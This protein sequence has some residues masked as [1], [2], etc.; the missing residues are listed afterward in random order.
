M[1]TYPPKPSRQAGCGRPSL[2]RG[3]P[4]FAVSIPRSSDRRAAAFT[5]LAVSF[6]VA[7][8]GSRDDGGAPPAFPDGVYRQTITRQDIVGAF[9]QVGEDLIRNN[10]GVIT[11]RFSHRTITWRQQPRYA[12]SSNTS[13][14]GT[15]RVSGEVIVVHWSSCGG[16]PADET[17]HWK[18]DGKLLRLHKNTTDQGDIIIWNLE[19]LVK[20]G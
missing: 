16:C 17:I 10:A 9:P 7:C 8:S 13:G 5:A 6:L 19:P 14:K 4:L 3:T 2:E 20:I 11:Y 1:A 15:Y 12:I 18:W